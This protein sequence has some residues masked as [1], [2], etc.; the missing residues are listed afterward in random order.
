MSCFISCEIGSAKIAKNSVVCVLEPEEH[1][2]SDL[3]H[4]YALAEPSAQERT[5]WDV[6]FRAGQKDAVARIQNKLKE[7][8]IHDD[9]IESLTRDFLL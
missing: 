1:F 7:A 2:F 8:G 6:A 4:P 9:Q 5:V 3:V